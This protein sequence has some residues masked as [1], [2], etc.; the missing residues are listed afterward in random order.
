MQGATGLLPQQNCIQKFYGGGGGGANL[1]YR[2]KR[3]SGSSGIHVRSS[4]VLNVKADHPLLAINVN[5]VRS[6]KPAAWKVRET[7]L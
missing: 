5:H 7:S 2:R 4:Q 1:G 3:G 6:Y